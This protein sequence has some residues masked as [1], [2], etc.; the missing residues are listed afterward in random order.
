MANKY[1]ALPIPEKQI[2]ENLYNNEYL[3]QSE[4]GQR[5]GT[6]QKVVFTWFIKLGIQSRIPF[7]RNQKRENNTSWKGDNVTYAAFHYRVQSARGKADHCEEC[8]KIDNAVF[9]WANMTGN[10]NDVMDYKMMCRSCHFKFDKI[11]QNF[12]I[13]RLNKRKLINEQCK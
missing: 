7:K 2:L 12:R 3:S 5:Y 1:T 10:F 13:K 6:T 11:G 4:I 9:D 8:G